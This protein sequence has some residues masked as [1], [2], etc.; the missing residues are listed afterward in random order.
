MNFG[1]T[2]APFQLRNPL[3]DPKTIAGDTPQRILM[4]VL[5]LM[6]NKGICANLPLVE[7]IGIVMKSINHEDAHQIL[8]KIENEFQKAIPDTT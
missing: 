6:L 2:L 4:R 3:K 1:E 7:P 8:H 5:K